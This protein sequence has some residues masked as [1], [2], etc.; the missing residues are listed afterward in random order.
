M[1]IVYRVE[2]ARGQGPYLG[3]WPFPGDKH[4]LDHHYDCGGPHPGPCELGWPVD[5]S[6]LYGFAF[7]CDALRWFRGAWSALRRNGFR[8]V[9]YEVTGDGILNHDPET[10]QVAFDPGATKRLGGAR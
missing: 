9:R 10:G 6:E 7:R 8:L 5:R 4:V 3:Q 2:N 1:A